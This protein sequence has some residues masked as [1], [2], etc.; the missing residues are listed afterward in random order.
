[1][2]SEKVFN[3]EVLNKY[4]NL[5][6]SQYEGLMKKV[7]KKA[8]KSDF[9]RLKNYHKEY[10]IDNEIRQDY[11]KVNGDIGRQEPR[12]P[13]LVYLPSHI[14]GSLCGNMID[15]DMVNS[16]P[17]IVL[18]LCKKHKLDHHHLSEYVYKREEKLKEIMEYYNTT[19]DEAKNEF[20]KCLN[21]DT[22]TTKINKKNIKKNSFYNCYQQQVLNIVN[23]LTNIYKNNDR[24]QEYYEKKNYNSGGVF[25]SKVFHDYEDKFLM[26]A[27]D[28][29]KKVHFQD[30]N[31]G[32]LF[33]DG[34]MYYE[35]KKINQVELIQLLNNRFQD[36]GIK[37]I[38]KPHKTDLLKYLDEIEVEKKDFF[39]GNDIIDVVE[40]ILDGILKNKI[41]KCDGL[42]Y[43]MNDKIIK[44]N[45]KQIKQE[46]YDFISKQDYYIIS[47]DK[48]G[49]E[50][51]KN[52]SRNH[53][54]IKQLVESIMNKCKNEEDFI[55]DVWSY[56][57]YK[58]FFLNGYFD[59]KLNKFIEG[60][61]NKTFIKI[62]RKYRISHNEKLRNE[63]Y[64]KIFNPIFTIV[65]DDNKETRTQLLN[66]FL[67]TTS[68]FLGG[69]IE[70]KK[71]VLLQGFRNSGKGIIGDLL[72]NCFEKYVITTNSSNFNFKKNISDSQKL[73]SWL[74]DYQFV[75]IALTSEISI[76][77][78]EK[79]D[80]NMIKK[81]TSGGDYMNARKNFQDEREFK[82][83]SSL[84]VCCNDCPK[85]EP[86]DAMEFCDEFQMK[87]KF[88]DDDFDK[89]EKFN[90]FQY[91]EKDNTLK[92]DFLKRED[93]INELTNIFFECYSNKV[94]YPQSL[95]KENKNDDDNEYKILKSIFK[96][97]ND[98]KD[99]IN[100]KELQQYMKEN[101]ISFTIKKVKMLLKTEGAKDKTYNN[102]RGLNFIK[103]AIE[104]SDD[105][106]EDNDLDFGV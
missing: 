35:N 75:R 62:N 38:I 82:I 100:N 56:T 72:K 85:I 39:S 88:I 105:E 23:S 51:T 14:R 93:I 98:E 66:N 46:L 101:N 59:Y 6:L 60:E 25:I 89:E 102:K 37:W 20:I 43:Y 9:T 18:Y 41:V 80:G 24:F 33:K 63:I 15:V 69:N 44:Q 4:S 70:L 90:G 53:T 45:E 65:D 83:Q 58:M 22:L 5:S 76:S 40:H 81:F 16:Q 50:T 86:S 73:L 47:F 30:L 42:V 92:S 67:Y 104:E 54:Y 91:F 95:R 96:I 99:F 11:Y 64:S 57:Q 78:D 79:I 77:E 19:R 48:D 97:T 84:I 31:V 21:K 29:L 7:N 94:E 13:S 103:Y 55:N 52:V 17:S 71:W 26:K 49:K 34:F 2:F 68:Q 8:N 32:V 27:I 1:M 87:S 106:D 28:Y 3:V 12:K 10:S 61:Y 36:Y 74:I